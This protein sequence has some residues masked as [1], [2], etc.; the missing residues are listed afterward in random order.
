MELCHLSGKR[1]TA[2]CR[3]ALTAYSDQIPADIALPANDLCPIH[4]AKAQAVDEAALATLPPAPPLRAIP[5]ED[6]EGQDIPLRAILV[7]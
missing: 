2:G 7:E 4:P 1:A 6:E 3:E 5:V